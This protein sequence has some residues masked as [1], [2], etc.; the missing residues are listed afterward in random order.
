MPV[1][2]FKHAVCGQVVVD[3]RLGIVN[4]HCGSQSLFKQSVK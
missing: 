3:S 1:V 2:G 4:G